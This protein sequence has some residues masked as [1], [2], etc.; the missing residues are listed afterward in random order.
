MGHLIIRF[1]SNKS[2]LGSN[3]VHIQYYLIFNRLW[4]FCCLFAGLASLKSS[5]KSH[6]LCCFCEVWLLNYGLNLNVLF[7]SYLCHFDNQ[8]I[9]GRGGVKMSTY[10]NIFQR[11]MYKL[12]FFETFCIFFSYAR[13]ATAKIEFDQPNLSKRIFSTNFD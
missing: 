5:Q 12:I 1:Q 13:Y 3:L 8:R 11:C 7:T 6:M 2:K 4:T 10:G 9:G